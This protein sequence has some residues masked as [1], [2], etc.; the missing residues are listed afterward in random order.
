MWSWVGGGEQTLYVNV[1]IL[2]L[3]VYLFIYSNLLSFTCLLPVVAI[4]VTLLIL[5]ATTT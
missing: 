3:F 4:V 2:K 1:E 5:V